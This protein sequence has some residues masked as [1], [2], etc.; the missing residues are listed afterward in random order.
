MPKGARLLSDE[1]IA[2]IIRHFHATAKMASR[3]GF[4]FVDIKH[5]HG[6]LGHEFLSA[7][8]RKGK[9]G[10]NFENRTRFL[11]EVVEGI[12]AE[13]PKLKIA[14]RLSAFDTVPFR[15]DPTR[16]HDHK[17]GPRRMLESRKL[18]EKA[19]RIIP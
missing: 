18:Q 7:Y 15:A 12:R 5:C 3:I 6:Y 16:A 10:G 17:L 14:V 4:D 11:K 13:A 2:A 9:Y 8:T 1:E 19:G